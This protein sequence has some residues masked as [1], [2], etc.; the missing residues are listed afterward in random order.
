[1]SSTRLG[2]Y[3]IDRGF[4]L[5]RVAPMQEHSMPFR[6]E[7]LRRLQTNAIGGASQQDG[8]FHRFNLSARKRISSAPF[9]RGGL[10]LS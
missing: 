3:Q 4:K 6:C 1:M 7:D 8:L 9:L 10:K 2:R 5:R